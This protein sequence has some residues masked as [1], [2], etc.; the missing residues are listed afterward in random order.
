[1]MMKADAMSSSYESE[2][3]GEAWHL[4]RKV[5]LLLLVV[6]ATALG[7]V[8]LYRQKTGVPPVLFNLLADASLGL[9]VGFTARLALRDR[10]MLIQG[11]ASA[12]VTIIGLAILGYFTGWTSGIGPFQVGFVGVHWLDAQ[13]IHLSLPLEFRGTG[14]DLLDLVH[15]AIAMDLSWIALRVW[16]QSPQASSRPAL[17]APR[18]H[19]PARARS[20]Y[21]PA[22]AAVPAA[23]V[24]GPAP[25]RAPASSGSGLRSRIKRH[26]GERLASRPTA[27]IHGLRAKA[28]RSNLRQSHPVVRLAVHEEHRCPYCLEPVKRNDPR[29]TVECQIC[30]TLHHKDCWDITGNCQVP[31]L[32]TL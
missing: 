8:L 29:G 12:A 17:P 6:T 4:L 25:V 23:K 5:F 26:R 24:P 31:H 11:L 15:V 20:T 9:L 28:K 14:M 21:T 10:H 3:T 7:L 16:K 32:T 1:M 13:H 18:P 27:T 22:V 2:R 30:H 19:R